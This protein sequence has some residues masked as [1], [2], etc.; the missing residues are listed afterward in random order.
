M[1][2]DNVYHKDM[3]VRLQKKA[4]FVGENLIVLV[5]VQPVLS[6]CRRDSQNMLAEDGFLVNRSTFQCTAFLRL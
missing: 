1:C 2:Q 5:T 6:K 4:I 3:C